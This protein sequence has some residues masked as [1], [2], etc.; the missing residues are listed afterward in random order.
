MT[1]PSTP[2]STPPVTPPGDTAAPSIVSVS[3]A[4]GATGVAK[5]TNVV[6][7]FSK[8]MNQSTTLSPATFAWNAEGTV[9]TVKP[10]ADL[11]Y[12][13]SGKDYSYS[14]TTTATD[15]AGNP[16][17]SNTAVSFKTYRQPTDTLTGQTSDGYVRNDNETLS[18]VNVLAVGDY[19]DNQATRAFTS[20]D[21]SSLPAG[22]TVD[23]IEGANL[24]LYVNK[25][26]GDPLSNLFSSAKCSP[27]CFFFGKSVIVD[28]VHFGN[29]LSGSS[30]ELATLS[31]TAAG[32]YAENSNPKLP[33]F[34]EK[35]WNSSDVSAMLRADWQ[36]RA[37]RGSLSQFRLRFPLGT[38]AD[39]LEDHIYLD[40]AEGAN[41]PQLILTY[42]IP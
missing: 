15:K 23:N 11:V 6:I 40:S 38:N 8:A 22:L 25:V 35:G 21:L 30:F 32:L 24:R 42:L 14:L 26:V 18:E 19:L 1:P 5:G 36:E 27:Y 39:N 3:P 37:T 28:S 34:T 16:L 7:T 29:A 4:A 13:S 10:N 12:T 17:G 9:M 33:K 41:K 2:P 31:A 20:F